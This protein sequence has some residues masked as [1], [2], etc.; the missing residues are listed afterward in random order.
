MASSSAIPYRDIIQPITTSTRTL[1]I[2]QLAILVHEAVEPDEHQKA[3]REGQMNARSNSSSHVSLELWQLLVAGRLK[4]A[5][6]RLN[7]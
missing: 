4:R 2:R 3:E 7:Q 5:T 6:L 1:D